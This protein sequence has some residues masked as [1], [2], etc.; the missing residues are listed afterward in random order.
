MDIAGPQP[1]QSEDSWFGLVRVRSPLLTESFVIFFSSGYLDVSVHRVPSHTLCIHV[2]VTR[3]YSSW[4]SPFGNLW[5]DACLLVKRN[6]FYFDVIQVLHNLSLSQSSLTPSLTLLQK[7]II[8]FTGFESL[9]YQKHE[10]GYIKTR[11]TK[12]YASST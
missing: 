9:V 12:Q 8:S 2:G 1:Q 7:S 11:R 5:I 10:T 6:E 4:V 3:H